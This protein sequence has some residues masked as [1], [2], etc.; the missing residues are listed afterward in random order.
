MLG[1]S[2]QQRLSL[3][4]VLHATCTAAAKEWWHEIDLWR[5]TVMITVPTD[6]LQRLN[7]GIPFV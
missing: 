2:Y 6:R 7:M 5:V 1:L 4:P 3:N